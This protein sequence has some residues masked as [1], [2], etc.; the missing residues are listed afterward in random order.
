MEREELI[1]LVETD[2]YFRDCYEQH[3]VQKEENMR[4]LL[5]DLSDGKLQEQLQTDPQFAADYEEYLI[6]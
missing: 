5:E 1:N 4:Q 2:S 3:M 6:L